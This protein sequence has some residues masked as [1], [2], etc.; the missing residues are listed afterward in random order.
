MTDNTFTRVDPLMVHDALLY[1]PHRQDA[2][3]YACAALRAAYTEMDR[4]AATSNE[5]ADILRTGAYDE[6]DDLLTLA[7]NAHDAQV[8]LLGQSDKYRLEAKDLAAERDRLR[9]NALE[10]VT[11]TKDLATLPEKGRPVLIRTGRYYFAGYR[12]PGKTKCW[13]INPKESSCDT[14]HLFVGDRWAY[15]PE[16][17]A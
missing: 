7:R 13:V 17:Q 4:M 16:A 10:W 11:V 8:H 12:N 3:D 1:G 14:S 15:I 5:A 6:D 9:A 2:A